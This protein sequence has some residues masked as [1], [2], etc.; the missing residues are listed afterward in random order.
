MLY[1]YSV[2]IAGFFLLPMAGTVRRIHYLLVFPAALLLWREI[3]AFCRDSTVFRLL[4][5]YAGWMMLSLAWTAD[6]SPQAAASQ[7]WITV[8]L[9]VFVAVSGYLWCS[10]AAEVDRYLPWLAGLAAAAALVSTLAWYWDNPFPGSRLVPLG[11]MHHPNKSGA[12]YG[13]FL[14]LCIQLGITARSRR[15]LYVL[16]AA[17][18]GCLVVF[19]QSRTALAATCVGVVIIL[20]WRALVPVAIGTALS[21]TLVASN[22]EEWWARVV[23]F[24]FRPGIWEAVIADMSGH[25]LLG[26]G[27]LVDPHVEAYDMV[28]NHAH[29]GY[30]ATLRDGGLV[31]LTLLLAVFGAALWQAA[32]IW[33]D[34]SERIYLALL[35]YG[36]TCISMDFDRLLVQPKEM[37][38][39]L[40]LPLALVAAAY[41]RRADTRLPQFAVK[42]EP[43]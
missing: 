16:A 32:R 4:M 5:V 14:V 26:L 10:H 7:L 6:F 24:S 33:R 23:S 38:L 13:L 22:P 11:A 30:L 39:Y 43:E 2:F 15:G 35:L 20:G 37:W 21:W 29:N 40:W 34:R 36:M 18:L 8:N 17:I 42:G 25:W 9:L 27:Y 1:I 41:P 12:V 31:G 28:F 19:T 3:S